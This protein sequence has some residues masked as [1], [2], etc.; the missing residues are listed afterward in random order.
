MT[1]EE[2]KA[3]LGIIYAE[4]PDV[5]LTQERYALWWEQIK[6]L[7]FNIAK[8]AALNL[9]EQITYGAPK[10]VDFKRCLDNLTAQ[11]EDLETADEAW[12]SMW[13]RE[14]GS[15]RAKATARLVHDW[16]NKRLWNLE[17][18]VP[19]KQKEFIRIYNG[20]KEKDRIVGIKDGMTAIENNRTLKLSV[21][22]NDLVKKI[23]D[24]K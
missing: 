12:A 4:Y 13:L 14:D 17:T 1:K 19:W 10:F 5:K 20:L 22:T 6:E 15:P 9:S 23:K 21:I 7:D 24:V 3:L 2:L 16:S 18:E 11:P 8:K